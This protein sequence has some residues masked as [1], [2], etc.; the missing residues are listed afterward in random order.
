MNIMVACSHLFIVLNCS[1]NFII[2][3]WKDG[4]FR[5]LLFDQLVTYQPMRSL[6]NYCHIYSFSPAMCEPSAFFS[7]TPQP[8]PL[9]SPTG[10]DSSDLPK[11]NNHHSLSILDFPN[12]AVV[13]IQSPSKRI[14][15]LRG[16]KSNEV[17]ADIIGYPSTIQ[18]DQDVINKRKMTPNN[19]ERPL[20]MLTMPSMSED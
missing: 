18:D 7:V 3:C 16:Q 2:Y 14:R 19:L 15:R 1:V 17:S 12:N 8:T 10:S 9:P 6:L 5:K 20:L 11:I 13:T 4:K